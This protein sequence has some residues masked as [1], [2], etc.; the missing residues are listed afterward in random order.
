[1][2]P[3]ILIIDDDVSIL[4]LIGLVLEEEGGYRV[5][6]S[7]SIFQDLTEVE[8]LRPDMIILDLRLNNGENGWA[9]LERLNV[10]HAL[11]DVPLLLCSAT[12]IDPTF[13]GKEIAILQKPFGI[14]ELLRCAQRGLSKNQMA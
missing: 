12:F 11:K 13:E 4:E 7:M 14:D 1:M 10:H 5:T 3:H 6:L 8:C 9:F 2:R